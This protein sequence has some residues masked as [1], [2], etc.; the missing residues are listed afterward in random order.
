MINN[1]DA[2]I[3]SIYKRAM[4]SRSQKEKDIQITLKEEYE[5]SFW[6]YLFTRLENLVKSVMIIE[7]NMP[8]MS[9]QK[10]DQTKNEISDLIT[11]VNT[12]TLPEVI[13]QLTV[14]LAKKNMLDKIKKEDN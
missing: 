8:N 11:L 6:Q 10:I 5:K 3:E 14:D 13:D 4:I 2:Y 7:Q 9:K 12:H 1:E